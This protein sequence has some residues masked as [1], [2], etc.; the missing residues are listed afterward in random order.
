MHPTACVRFWCYLTE[1]R[2]LCAQASEHTASD[3]SSVA[4]IQG[5]ERSELRQDLAYL[6]SGQCCSPV[7]IPLGSIPPGC[8]CLVSFSI[9]VAPQ[10]CEVEDPS[11]PAEHYSTPSTCGFTIKQ[12][13]EY[14]TWLTSHLSGCCCMYWKTGCRHMPLNP[15]KLC[16]SIIIYAADSLRSY[17]SGC[18]CMYWK[19]GCRRMVPNPFKLCK[20]TIINSCPVVFRCTR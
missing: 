1:Y 16:K 6:L 11:N 14:M 10:L 3:V 8:S 5:E 7:T 20:S 19:T 9:P 18:C 15:F 4:H 12:G 13:G 2:D 17:L